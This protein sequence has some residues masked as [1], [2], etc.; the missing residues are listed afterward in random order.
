MPTEDFFFGGH[1]FFAIK[2]SKSVS[3]FAYEEGL[4]FS[5]CSKEA[6]QYDN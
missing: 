2:D 4:T 3:F 1:Y 5:A 6:N